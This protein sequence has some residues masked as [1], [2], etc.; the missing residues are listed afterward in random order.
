MSFD[1]ANYIQY[2]E[3]RSQFPTSSFQHYFPRPVS[4]HTQRWSSNSTSLFK[5]CFR[6]ISLILS[7][8]VDVVSATLVRWLIFILEPSLLA[9]ASA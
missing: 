2:P 6:V 7:V 8:K 9:N 4:L 1:C 5:R 3:P